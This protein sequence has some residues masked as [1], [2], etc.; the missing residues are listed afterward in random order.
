[1][2]SE[3]K[4]GPQGPTRQGER[5]ISTT[6]RDILGRYPFNTEQTVNILGEIGPLASMFIVNGI[7]GIAAGTWALIITTILSLAVSLVV[8][9]RPPIM[10]FIAGAVSVVFG[11]LT[12]VTGDAK[13]VQ[14][15]VTIFNTLV[16]A[17][18]ALGLRTGH[19]FFRFVFGETFR[20]RP[21]GW[22]KLTRNM[23]WFFLA[24]AIVN[25]MVRLGF[26]TTHF[27]AL[28]HIFTGVDIW[29]L[30]KLFIVMPATAMFMW[31]QVHLLQ[32]YR[33]PDKPQ[34]ARAR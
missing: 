24:T 13:W 32:R 16:A 18:L 22:H 3:P 23:A 30:F 25:E 4:T 21:A 29:I 20:Y 27:M 10:P 1:M 28:N 12:L 33:L 26:A 11:T 5:T 31:W 2:L 14:I 8:L 19:N 17:L 34:P 9:G 6:A 15:K 7:H